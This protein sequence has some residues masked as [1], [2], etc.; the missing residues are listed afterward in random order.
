MADLDVV[1]PGRWGC[2][3]SPRYATDSCGAATSRAGCCDRQCAVLGWRPT[4]CY[5]SDAGVLQPT[6]RDAGIVDAKIYCQRKGKLRWC[7]CE[8]VLLQPMAFFAGTGLLEPVIVVASTSDTHSDDRTLQPASKKARTGDGDCYNRRAKLMQPTWRATTREEGD[9]DFLLEPTLCFAG[10][11]VVG[12]SNLRTIGAGSQRP[13]FA[14]T[15]L[16][17]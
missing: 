14:G 15:E 5:G 4:R 7:N 11:G 17:L 8:G 1:S 9:N 13:F 6:E 2:V 16:R 3:G 12:R 10:T